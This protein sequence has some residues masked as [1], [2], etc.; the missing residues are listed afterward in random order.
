MGSLGWAIRRP[1]RGAVESYLRRPR[2]PHHRHRRLLPRHPVLLFSDVFRQSRRRLRR[3]NVAA[4]SVEKLEF[5]DADETAPLPR[6]LSPGLAGT[7]RGMSTRP[8][9]PPPHGERLNMNRN[10]QSVFD[11]PNIDEKSKP[12]LMAYEEGLQSQ[13]EL[14]QHRLG[15]H[16]EMPVDRQACLGGFTT[17]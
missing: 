6:S 15:F 3:E 9:E 16:Q 12:F 8:V 11:N 1:P 5:A 2:P 10:T 17:L 7:G 14:K 13:E 4:A